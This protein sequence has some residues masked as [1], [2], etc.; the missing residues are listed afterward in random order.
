MRKSFA[1]FP[2]LVACMLTGKQVSAQEK[3]GVHEMSKDY[4]APKDPLVI[5][6][7]SQ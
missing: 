4:Q 3:E 1:V 2:L 6:K 7:L 5:R